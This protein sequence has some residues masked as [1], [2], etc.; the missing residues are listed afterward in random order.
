VPKDA[1]LRLD[2]DTGSITPAHELNE[3]EAL[4]VMLTLN[5]ITRK[6]VLRAY[7]TLHEMYGREDDSWQFERAQGL[8]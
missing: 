2:L 4:H 1:L 5:G 3:H 6:Q 7:R 8:A